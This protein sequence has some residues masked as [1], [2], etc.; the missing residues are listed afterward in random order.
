VS[1]SLNQPLMRILIIGYGSI[2]KRHLKNLKS[3][4]PNFSIAVLRHDIS[5][6]YQFEL[7]NCDHCF[8]DLEKAIKFKPHAAIIA[9]PS[10]YHIKI[11][12]ALAK[13]KVNL[14]VEKPLSSSSKNVKELIEICDKNRVL[15]KVAYNL[16][17]LSSLQLFR[18]LI[19]QGKIGKILS[20]HSTVGQYLP[21]WRP[22]TDYRKT[23]SAQSSL[24]GGAL[25]ELSHEIDYI[26]WI[27]GKITSVAAIVSKQS[28][29]KIDVEDTASLLM[30]V[31]TLK[32]SSKI[33]ISLNMDFNRHD[34]TRL[35]YAIGEKGTLKWNGV[36][37]IVEYNSASENE[38]Q[39]LYSRRVN[40]NATYEDEIKA[41]IEE[42]SGKESLLLATGSEGFS[43]VKVIESAKKSSIEK[44]FVN[45]N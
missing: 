38:F 24:G 11:A 14:L 36:S 16:R 13:K 41:F 8:Y 30:E 29:L 26:E 2:G 23:V 1:N 19:L 22:N 27:F 10:S 40:R 5:K 12:I 28:N 33:V 18:K 32:D 43:V 35:C 44:C 15:L 17:F 25:L 4:F 20:V 34:Q 9:N 42:I 7:D 39:V 45:L 21:D 37:N 31:K 6:R 3:Y